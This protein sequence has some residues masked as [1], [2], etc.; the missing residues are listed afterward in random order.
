[1]NIYKTKVWKNTLKVLISFHRDQ[2]YPLYKVQYERP[3]GNPL[4]N[5]FNYAA[6]KLPPFAWISQREE[7]PILIQNVCSHWPF[8]A[9]NLFENMIAS[10][11]E[12]EEPTAGSS[13]QHTTATTSSISNNLPSTST[14][15]SAASSS[16]FFNSIPSTS[17]A[18]I[19]EIAANGFKRMKTETKVDV[20]SAQNGATF[21]EIEDCT[22]CCNEYQS[23]ATCPSLWKVLRCGH[24][25]CSICYYQIQNTGTTMSGVTHTFVKCPYCQEV[26]G[27]QIGVCPDIQMKIRTTPTS[28]RGYEGS[29]TIVITYINNDYGL[30]RHAYLPNIAEGREVLEL[31]K[32][33]W[34][35]RLSFTIGDSVTTGRLNTIV[36]NVHH[37]TSTEGGVAKYGYPDPGYFDRVKSEL[38]ELGIE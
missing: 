35:R 2:C 33:A 7:D 17:R 30:K 31:L 32:T 38:K 22:I 20:P 36:W 26:T 9:V 25:L 3:S 14:G 24:R 19:A 16:S 21:P 28:C 1:M 37:K 10:P 18:S 11:A 15:I 27:T 13:K 12:D 6:I 34:D 23:F 8:F 5:N 29:N 4:S